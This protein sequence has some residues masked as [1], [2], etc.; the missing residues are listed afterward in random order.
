MFSYSSLEIKLNIK[1]RFLGANLSSETQE[2]ISTGFHARDQSS[3]E[4]VRLW[5]K[6]EGGQ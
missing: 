3:H 2:T 1:D 4:C 5:V 6:R